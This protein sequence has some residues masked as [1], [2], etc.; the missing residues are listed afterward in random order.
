MTDTP[1]D[2]YGPITRLFTP[3]QVECLVRTAGEAVHGSGADPGNLSRRQTILAKRAYDALIAGYEADGGHPEATLADLKA[4]AARLGAEIEDLTGAWDAA[5]EVDTNLGADV[6]QAGRGLEILAGKLAA[7]IGQADPQAE[8]DLL[9]F[10]ARLGEAV[11]YYEGLDEHDTNASI[12]I[13]D[14]LGPGIALLQR[15]IEARENGSP[16][17]L[18]EAIAGLRGSMIDGY[19]PEDVNR[20]LGRIS[21]AAGLDLVC[22]WDTYDSCG[23]GGNSQF[24]VEEQDGRLR[25]L[26]GDLWRWLNDDPGDPD[27]PVIPGAPSS[28]AGELA[29]FTTADLEYDDGS[30]NY[31]RRDRP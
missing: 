19:C 9:Q 27:A 17:G 7:T 16:G 14:Q 2:Q 20:I 25:D 18:L 26:A 22:V 1:E 24:Y 30:C 23:P 5:D 3:G 8:Q 31:A 4:D 28:W 29:D 6:E 13:V 21:E 12:E 11:D 10:A 15:T